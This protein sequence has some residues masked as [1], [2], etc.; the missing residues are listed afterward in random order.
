MEA[1]KT[2]VKYK[3]VKKATKM[4]RYSLF[5]VQ[6]AKKVEQSRLKQAQALVYHQ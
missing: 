4:N 1:L 3:R 5:M 6:L 2:Y